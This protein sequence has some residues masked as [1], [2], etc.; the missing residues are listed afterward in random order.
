MFILE[1]AEPC[2]LYLQKVEQFRCKKCAEV[3]IICG[4]YLIP[5]FL[6]L[7]EVKKIKTF[8]GIRQVEPP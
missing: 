5:I 4:K 8:R 3:F 1:T 7:N 6:N 2:V